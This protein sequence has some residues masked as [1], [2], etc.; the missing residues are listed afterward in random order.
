M[1]VFLAN[2]LHLL[3]MFFF[4]PFSFLSV[5]LFNVYI[6]EQDKRCTIAEHLTGFGEDWIILVVQCRQRTKAFSI[7]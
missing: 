3:L 2:D 6:F 4:W 5:G 7:S 1:V